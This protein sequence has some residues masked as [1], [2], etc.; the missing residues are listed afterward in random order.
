MSGSSTGGAGPFAGTYAATL[1]ETY[2][3]DG[4]GPQP[5]TASASIV[6]ADGTTTDMVETITSPTISGGSCMF[7]YNRT[8]S[9][10]AASPADQTCS[11]T[12]SNGDKQTNTD[13]AH[14]ATIN[15]NA[16]TINISGTFVGTTPQ[17]VPYSGTFSGAW[18]GT[19]Q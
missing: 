9:S 19:R 11:Y 8:D 6:F 2:T 5:L 15:G 10:A 3:V 18:T 12:L 4:S 1:S 14:M 7:T 16:L 17:N 13:S